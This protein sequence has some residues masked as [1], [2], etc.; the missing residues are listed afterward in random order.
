MK[1][2]LSENMMRFGTKNLSV[3]AQKELIVKSI[4]ETID[5]HM[6]HGIVRHRLTEA[7]GAPY[8][9]W[10]EK[11]GMTWPMGLK[12]K[13]QENFEAFITAPNTKLTTA[14]QKGAP[15]LFTQDPK[16][17]QFV[18]KNP[19]GAPNTTYDVSINF[20]GAHLFTIAAAAGLKNLVM[21]STPTGL[22]RIWSKVG[23]VVNKMY[24]PKSGFG[25]PYGIVE[26][27][28]DPTNK[29]YADFIKAWSYIVNTKLQPVY[30]A[31]VA[32]YAILPKQ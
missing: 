9:P 15:S 5:Q 26:I 12:F 2:T 32:A 31:N 4:M 10:L 6:L 30:M 29:K 17:K 3:S 25:S 22:N 27:I 24:S 23:S 13:S 14:D 7:P 18:V 8:D 16:T 28:T 20:M 21:V 11:A 19:G 1:N